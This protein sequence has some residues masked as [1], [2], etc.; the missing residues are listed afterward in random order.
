[1]ATDDAGI[2]LIITCHE[3]NA[4]ALRDRVPLKYEG[5]RVVI[6]H[7]NEVRRDNLQKEKEQYE[8]E[9]KKM[10]QELEA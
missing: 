10:E 9:L 3:Q 4:K 7:N 1:M 8:E 2:H 6:M 5:F